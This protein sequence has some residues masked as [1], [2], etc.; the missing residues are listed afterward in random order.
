MRSVPSTST[1]PAWCLY[2]VLVDANTDDQKQAAILEAQVFLNGEPYALWLREGPT[3]GMDG[4][5]LAATARKRSMCRALCCDVQRKQFCLWRTSEPSLDPDADGHAR[6]PGVAR[7]AQSGGHRSNDEGPG[8]TRALGSLFLASRRGA[9]LQ[10]SITTALDA[11]MAASRYKL[12]ALA[13][14]AHVWHL[15]R[16]V[17]DDF[18]GDIDLDSVDG[19]SII[20]AGDSN[21]TEAV[22]FF[23]PLCMMRCFAA[24]DCTG[25]QL[26]DS[27]IVEM[28]GERA[29][30]DLETA[31]GKNRIYSRPKD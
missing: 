13:F 20:R 11:P 12:A 5:I 14:D 24:Y 6:F 25:Q 29:K 28:N 18:S 15:I 1:S 2:C 22:E 16:P 30:L 17:L 8:E 27:G 3:A 10:L 23:L 31:E 19:S 26:L 7:A 4:A 9:D 21:K